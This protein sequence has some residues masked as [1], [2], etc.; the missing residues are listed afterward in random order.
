[1]RHMGSLGRMMQGEMG[2]KGRMGERGVSWG[3]ISGGIGGV[4]GQTR[5]RSR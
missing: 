4:M 1:M 3:V 2:H 5:V